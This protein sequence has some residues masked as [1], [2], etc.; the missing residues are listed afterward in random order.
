MPVVAGGADPGPT[1]RLELVNKR[2]PGPEYKAIATRKRKR[3]KNRNEPA[4]LRRAHAA[5]FATHLS[6]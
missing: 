3:R 6:L 5:P 4:G 1:Q 2:P